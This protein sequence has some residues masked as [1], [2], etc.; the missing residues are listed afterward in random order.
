MN[1]S[2]SMAG[3]ICLVTGA[4]SGIGRATA[5]ALARSGA[6]LI[7]HGRDE[8]KTREFLAEL[9]AGPDAGD[10]HMVLADF[11][12]LSA[13]RALADEIRERF[14]ALHV[15]VNNAGVLT[16]RRKVSDDGFEW[17]FAVNHLASFLLSRL[18]FDLLQENA[19]ARIAF[20]SSSAMGG[21]H[22]DFSDLQME[23]TFDGWTAYANTKLA[24]MLTANLLAEMYAASGVVSNSFCPGL[25]DTNLLAGNHDF[26]EAGIARLQSAMRSV[27]DGAITPVFLASAPQAEQINGAYFLKSHGNGTTPLQIRWDRQAAERLWSVS[28]DYVS[29]WLD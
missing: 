27:E 2:S 20:N 25:I 29:R 13:V 5:E 4:T 1:D 16:D 6:T 21:A 23:R 22:L 14:G 12:S 9:K 15:L 19:P 8:R 26:G 18:L 11:A 24:N 3:R 10:A 17:T 28:Q 7:V